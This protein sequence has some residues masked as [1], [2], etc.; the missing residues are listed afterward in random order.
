M[1]VVDI[2]SVDISKADS[3]DVSGTAVVI[4]ETPKGETKE[5]S[6]EIKPPKEIPAKTTEKV[7]EKPGKETGKVSE[8]F[9]KV[10]EKEYTKEQAAEYLEKV[11]RYQGDRDKAEAAVE[12]VI[13]Q[14]QG[15]G[16]TVDDKWNVVPVQRQPVQPSREELT[17]LAAAGDNQALNTLLEMHGNEVANKV[18]GSIQYAEQNKGIIEKVKKEYPDFYGADGQP[19]LESPLS[20]EAARVLE[21]HPEMGDTKYLPLV[22]QIAEANLIKGNLKNFEQTIKDKTHTKLAQAA[23]Q[24]LGTPG[25][26]QKEEGGEYSEE[27]LQ[28]AKKIGVDSE[29][30]NKIIK[31]ANERGG[32][33]I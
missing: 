9:L 3:G 23:S 15:A 7:E 1:G 18:Y 6:K 33:Q 14:L 4:D 28:F 17:L 22:A 8:P 20:K 32:Y 29:R 30:L 13:R 11:G 16:Y 26:V 21:Q 19:N 31:R 5:E 10:G 25:T 24:S 27:Q 2:E 12:R